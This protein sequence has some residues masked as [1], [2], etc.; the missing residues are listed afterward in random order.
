MAPTQQHSMVQSPIPT[1]SQVPA[2]PLHQSFQSPQPVQSPHQTSTPTTN[3]NQSQYSQ[4]Q[5]APINA[6]NNMQATGNMGP[7]TIHPSSFQ[8]A[9]DAAKTRTAP[10]K[11]QV[12][13]M[14]DMLLGTGIDLDEEAEY[15]NNLE[16]RTGY[17]QL[18]P[19]G[20]D[21]FYGAGPANQPAEPT[22]AKSQEEYA[23]LR[24][25]N[26]WNEAA[27]RLAVT[28]S[29]EIRQ[30]LLEPGVLHKRMHE[31][32][33]KFGLGLNVDLKPDGKSQYMGKFSQPAEFPKPELKIVFQPDSKGSGTMVNTMGSF[34][35]KEAFLVDQIALLSIGTKERLRDLLSDAHKIAE[36]RQKSSH[37]TV[38]AEWAEA[39]APLSSKVN[40]TPSEST[41]TG[42]ESAV[43]PRTN[44]LKR[45]RLLYS[46][47]EPSLA[48]TSF[49][50][51]RR[52]KRAPYTN[53][54]STYAKLFH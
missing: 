28:R 25:D 2:Q 42:A 34:I 19:G 40:G 24:A 46:T 44:V 51:I 13:E 53:L 38:P 35:P 30:Y 6:S 37:G 47:S 12:Y 31:V 11:G 14:N 15:M 22:D 23:A 54:G 17:S 1:P 18:P 8:A 41:R 48:N 29:Q 45:M 27:R 3:I 32:A 20:R 7:P 16:T 50:A 39:A 26:V 9:N 36:T 5:L 33:Q 49:R 43:S 52:H 4:A 21:S 10:S